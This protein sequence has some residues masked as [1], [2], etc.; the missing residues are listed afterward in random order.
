M[1]KPVGLQSHL[2][3]CSAACST[4]CSN[5]RA[6]EF[7]NKNM[8]SYNFNTY[9]IFRESGNVQIKKFVVGQSHSVGAPHT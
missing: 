9:R 6:L 3:W 7:N 1:T 5:V 4:V 2:D 8:Q